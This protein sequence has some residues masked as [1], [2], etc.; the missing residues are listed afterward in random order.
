MDCKVIEEILQ[1]DKITYSE[2][3]RQIFVDS[4]GFL[5]QT[6]EVTKRLEVVEENRG[7]GCSVQ[8][9]VQSLDIQVSVEVS[10]EILV[11]TLSIIQRR[12]TMG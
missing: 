6:L 11:M 3:I 7:V 9:Q 5:N 4:K 1:K 10:D 2:G 12:G 8:S